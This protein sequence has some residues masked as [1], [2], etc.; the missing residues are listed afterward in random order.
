LLYSFD[1]KYFGSFYKAIIGQHETLRVGPVQLK[2]YM[3]ISF[4]FL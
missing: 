4:L 2:D 3:V 1:D